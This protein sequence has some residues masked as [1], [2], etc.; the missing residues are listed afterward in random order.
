[1][2]VPS[3]IAVLADPKHPFEVRITAASSRQ[4]LGVRVG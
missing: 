4:A 1:V 3:D 2:V